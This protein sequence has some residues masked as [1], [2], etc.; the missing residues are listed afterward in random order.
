VVPVGL[1]KKDWPAEKSF[2]A[3]LRNLELAVT[4]SLAGRVKIRCPEKVNQA[5]HLIA[6]KAAEGH[7]R[8]PVD[9][10]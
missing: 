1:K 10:K 5:L 3:A 6:L 4:P 2:A 8:S 7:S 9:G